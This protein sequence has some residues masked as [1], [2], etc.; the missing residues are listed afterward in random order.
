MTEIVR[1]PMPVRLRFVWLLP[2]WFA[3]AAA[4]GSTVAGHGGQLY[5]IGALVGVWASALIGDGAESSLALIPTL[6]GGVPVLALLGWLL[7][8]LGAELWLWL[9]AAAL[10]AGLAGYLLLQGY[11]DIESAITHHGSVF[12]YL[13]CAMQLGAYGA[14]L[15]VLVMQAGRGGRRDWA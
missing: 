1:L 2:L 6:L 3:I 8:R 7:D 11:S 14:T 12:A 15:I 5:F 10:C 13:V 9:T 4:I